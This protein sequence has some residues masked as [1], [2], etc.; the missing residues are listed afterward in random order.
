MPGV[1]G[2]VLRDVSR[3]ASVYRRDKKD[4]P[5]VRI[6]L[7]VHRQ[8]QTFRHR[9]VQPVADVT[10]RTAG[11]QCPY[12]DDV[13]RPRHVEPDRLAKMAPSAWRTCPA[14]CPR[15]ASFP[16]SQGERRCQEGAGQDHHGEYGTACSLVTRAVEVR[17][18]QGP[19]LRRYAWQRRIV[20]KSSYPC[21]K[22]TE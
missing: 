10:V 9:G 3:R 4:D 20:K 12:P 13:F 5:Q 18:R 11:R 14:Y 15:L 2:Q 17:C 22:K 1:S 8:A 19:Q 7:D 6:H 21:Y 16:A